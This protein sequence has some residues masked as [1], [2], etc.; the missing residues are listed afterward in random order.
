MTRV[1]IGL[2]SN[3]GDRLGR[4]QRSIDLM[5]EFV[6]LDGVSPVYETAPLY[7]EEQPW[8]FNA[9]ALG[10]TDLGP[11]ELL[12]RLKLVEREVGREARERY[13]PREVDLDV[14]IYGSAR[15]E[16]IWGDETKLLVPHPALAERAFVLRPLADL[17]P[18][19]EIPKFGRVS[20]LLAR[21][22]TP[23]SDVVLRE[24]AALSIH[25]KR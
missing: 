2:G 25:R 19:L 5:A 10:S 18:S 22:E 17:D 9:A 14:L 23:G 16:M 20:D 24:D 8:F 4:L 7:M 3:V 13:G 6:T 11:I 21:I 1:A 15:L 12:F